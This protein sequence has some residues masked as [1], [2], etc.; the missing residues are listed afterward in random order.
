MRPAASD[1]PRV[2]EVFEAARHAS[3]IPVTSLASEGFGMNRAGQRTSAGELT[4]LSSRRSSQEFRFGVQGSGG[5][6]VL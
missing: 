5:N 3:N 4:K 6:D 2:R 1:W